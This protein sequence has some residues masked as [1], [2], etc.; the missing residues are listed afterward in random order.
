MFGYIH[1]RVMKY[2]SCILLLVAVVLAAIAVYRAQSWLWPH[3][4]P[5][6]FFIDWYRVFNELYT[7]MTPALVAFTGAALIDRLDHW[8][9]RNSN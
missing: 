5:A 1:H 4:G 9:S 3:P 7:G 2:A 8:L 6:R